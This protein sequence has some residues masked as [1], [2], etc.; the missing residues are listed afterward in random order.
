M[1]N[2][3]HLPE[4]PGASAKR[5]RSIIFLTIEL[6][7]MKPLTLI[8][9]VSLAKNLVLALGLLL[10][11][12]V[13]QAWCKGASGKSSMSPLQ[14]VQAGKYAEALPGFKKMAAKSPGDRSEE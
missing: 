12:G 8:I 6:N 3:N 5:P 11:A 13:P 1:L 14:L 4:S 9:S 2:A 7:Q 10:L